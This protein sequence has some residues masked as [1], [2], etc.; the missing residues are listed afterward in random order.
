MDAVDAWSKTMMWIENNIPLVIIIFTFVIQITPI[1][2]N[3][4]SQLFKWIGKLI[5]TE[6]NKKIADLID[7]TKQL[8]KK[9]EDETRKLDNKITDLRIMVD[10]NEK[11]RIR[12]EVLN[13]ANSCHNHIRHTKD[14]FEHIIALND[15][16]NLLLERTGDK[17]GVYT[18]EYEYIRGIYTRLQEK[19]GF[20]NEQAS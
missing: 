20:I 17:N 14:E 4:W 16:Y 19:G 18:A 3:P 5:N 13:F 1:K 10:E 7:S 9:L 12:Y 8:N 6:M 11:D 15:K 2:W